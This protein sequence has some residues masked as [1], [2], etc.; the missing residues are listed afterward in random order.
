[1]SSGRSFTTSSASRHATDD[2]VTMTHHPARQDPPAVIAH[3]ST[4][5]TAK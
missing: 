2:K 1:M 4:Y 3:G 5:F